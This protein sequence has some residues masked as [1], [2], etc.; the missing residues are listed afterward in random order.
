M[1]KRWTALVALVVAV[2]LAGCAGEP[3]PTEVAP[4]RLESGAAFTAD[5]RVSQAATHVGA[6]AQ[7]A[8]IGICHRTGHGRFHVLINVS[9]NAEPAH[10]AHGDGK[11]D[12]EVP[13]SAGLKIF[14]AACVPVEVDPCDVGGG[15]VGG[16][17]LG[18][19]VSGDLGDGGGG[20]GD[21]PPTG[22]CSGVGP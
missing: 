8:K 21:A 6:A 20:K 18:P 14:D 15:D 4:D 3:L 9:Q 13:G 11:P 12:G 10:L 17:D 1:F 16:G 22:G 5:A 7:A 19:P 2:P